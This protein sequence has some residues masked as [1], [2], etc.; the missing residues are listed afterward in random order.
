MPVTFFGRHSR[1]CYNW[2]RLM[3]ACVI[4]TQDSRKRW[5]NPATLHES[6][7]IITFS[8]VEAFGSSQRLFYHKETTQKHETLGK[9]PC[10]QSKIRTVSKVN[11]FKVAPMRWG[12]FWHPTDHFK[13]IIFEKL[14]FWKF[15]SLKN[16]VLVTFKSKLVN[17]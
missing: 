13:R 3:K 12:S 14:P 15:C 7:T 2:Y 16:Y 10:V 9:K 4:S 6:E 11:H 8:T 17:H 5:E 1:K